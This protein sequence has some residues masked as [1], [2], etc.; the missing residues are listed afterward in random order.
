MTET[1]R[2]KKFLRHASRSRGF[3]WK[4]AIVGILA[5][6]VGG[7]VLHHVRPSPPEKLADRLLAAVSPEIADALSSD[8]YS[9]DADFL[10]REFERALAAPS[11]EFTHLVQA[12]PPLAPLLAAH[13]EQII[14]VL[15]LRF[16]A[17]ETS[18]TVD[19]I[20]LYS[21][22]R[23]RQEAASQRLKNSAA[24]DA[25][26][27]F[28]NHLL[29][30][31][32]MLQGNPTGAYEHFAKE[33]RRPEAAVSRQMAVNALIAGKNFAEFD[34]LSRNPAYADLIT[35]F[36]RLNVAIA[37]RDWP[38]ILR[39]VPLT[40]I[41]MQNDGLVTLTL[42]A[43]LAWAFFLFHLGETA[44]VFSSTT[45]LC[46]GALAL[47]VLSTTPAIYLLIWQ[48]EILQ[49]SAGDTSVHLLAYSVGGIGLREELC[50]LLLF[51]P[52][53]P[54]LVKRDDDREALLVASFVGLGFAIEEN[55]S[56]FLASQGVDAP[57]RFLT[58]NFLHIALT[59]LNGLA[60][61]R[62][63][64]GRTH[65]LSELLTV[66]P[67]TV[68]A[69]GLY[70]CLPGIPELMELGGYLAITLFVVSSIIYFNRANELR[71]NLPMTL[72]LTGA[73]IIGTTI[74]AAAVL[75]EQIA[76]FGPGPGLARVIPEFIGVGVLILMFLRVFN[77][78]LAE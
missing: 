73:F 7:V 45:L 78:A 70:N 49:L 50:K 60:L 66:F 52:M 47:G 57:S 41:S 42:I 28:A 51:V 64:A 21:S 34:R 53:L 5:G 9:S 31:R 38:A 74:V 77:E 15:P 68:L 14:H 39:F 11:V 62:A 71:E 58:A 13:S 6:M 72:S 33:G 20:S 32:E 69:H 43:G 30:I 37:R 1:P 23:S 55:G 56:Y 19:F 25:P 75:A 24:A 46:L 8:R 17:E 36:D 27:R 18:L 76:S 16:S 40:Q 26:S 63:C 54:F 65:A 2:W 48:D 29:G 59:G 10:L 12:L 4:L 61:F 67:L 44:A 35:P 22:D 3:L